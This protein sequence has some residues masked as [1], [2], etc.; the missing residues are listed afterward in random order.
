MTPLDEGMSCDAGACAA[1]ATCQDGTCIGDVDVNVCAPADECHEFGTCDPA[2]GTCF[3]PAV[4]DGDPCPGGTCE[5]GVCA[6]GQGG[7]GGGPSSSGGPGS[8]CACSTAP[9]S[10]APLGLSAL[11]ALVALL[12][13]RTS[14]VG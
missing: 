10:S 13:R 4:P 9:G 6:A 7:G 14:R 3:N 11:V 2:S 12:V 1:A 5:G 8:G